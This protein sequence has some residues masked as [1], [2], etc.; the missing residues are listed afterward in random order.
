MIPFPTNLLR[1]AAVAVALTTASTAG[2]ATLLSNL[3][4]A[5]TAGTAFGGIS[6]T[7]TK[8]AGWT[9]GS[10]SFA[11]SAVI[12]D[13]ETDAGMAPLVSIWSGAGAPTSSL[14]TLVNPTFGGD[15]LYSFTPSSAL[16][17]NAATS[18][19]LRVAV[20][21]SSSQ[22]LWSGRFGTP[23]GASISSF[24]GYLFKFLSQWLCSRRRSDH[25]G[26]PA[27]VAIAAGER[28]GRPAA[29]W[30]AQGPGL[31]SRRLVDGARASGSRHQS[32]CAR[33]MT[34]FITTKA[35]QPSLEFFQRGLLQ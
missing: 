26:S 2:A 5:G 29:A 14:M 24:D 19:W 6:T 21:G 33:T 16:T 15:G 31:T 27:C 18:Y 8:D 4:G 3:G 23:A 28:P 13:L 30:Q 12:L 32:F 25:A 9:M 17:L 11:L 1:A 22:W 34:R 20:D 10:D 7:V 35:R